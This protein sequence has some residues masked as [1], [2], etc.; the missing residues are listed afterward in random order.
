MRA[1]SS[2]RGRW[3]M[4][5]EVTMLCKGTKLCA[6]MIYVRTML[7]ERMIL[8]ERMMLCKGFFSVP[9]FYILSYLG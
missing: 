8:R 5:D 6:G 4:R 9:R 3:Y 2:A 7:H 1:Y